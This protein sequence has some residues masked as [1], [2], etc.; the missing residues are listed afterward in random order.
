MTMLFFRS[1]LFFLGQAMSAVFF[2][3]FGL[4]MFFF[5]Y[6][7]RYRFIT[8]WSHFVIWWAKVVCGIH[9]R[10]TG[11]E[12]LPAKAS[13]VLCKHQSAWETLFLQ[14]ILPPQ[15][16]VL[17]KSL[18]SIP[19]FGWGLRMLEPIAID[20]S[21][22]SSIKQLLSEGKK[23]LEE[24][25]WVVIFPEGSRISVGKCGKYS[26]SG[27]L[28]AKEADAPIVPIAHNAGVFWPKD[29]FIKRPGTIEVVIGPQIDPA[30][31]SVEEMQHQVKEWIEST[32]QS[33]PQEP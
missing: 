11:K 23:R 2:G 20:R 12:H 6:S 21:K 5:P 14:T 24:N 10:V 13:I 1:L 17:K 29:A 3:L 30:S 25:R 9:Y 8:S 33:L 26:K 32:T 16:W 31:S 15:S 27:I 4:M 7:F 28:L 22:S 18:L 19:F